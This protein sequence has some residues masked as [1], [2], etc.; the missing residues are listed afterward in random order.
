MATISGGKKELEKFMEQQVIA[1]LKKVQLKLPEYLRE[2]IFS[3]YYDQYQPT[4]L[5][6][7]QYRIIEAIMVSSIVKTGNTYTISIYL[8]PDKVSYDPSI[9][10]DTRF[11]SWGWIKGDEAEDVFNLMS[12]GIHGTYENGQTQGRFW[13]AFVDSINHGGIYDLFENFKKYLGG[14]GVLTIG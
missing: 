2:F 3:E 10:Y 13:E 5:Y 7:R 11:K 9:W 6:E 14:K 12:N 4:D 8:D 1:W